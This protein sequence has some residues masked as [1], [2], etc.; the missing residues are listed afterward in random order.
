MKRLKKAKEFSSIYQKES[1]MGVLGEETVELEIGQ[2]V[3]HINARKT[4]VSVVINVNSLYTV[5]IKSLKTRRERGVERN[6][7]VLISPLEYLKAKK[8]K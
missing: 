5:V 3:R 2:L 6:Q 7:L 4:H 8:A 1:N